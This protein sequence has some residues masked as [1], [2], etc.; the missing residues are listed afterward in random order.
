MQRRAMRRREKMARTMIIEC[1]GTLASSGFCRDERWQ[2]AWEK[3]KKPFSHAN[4]RL[5]HR[6]FLQKPFTEKKNRYRRRF[7]GDIES[8]LV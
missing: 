6:L 5:F 8:N 2:K 7:F 4:H 3:V 1:S